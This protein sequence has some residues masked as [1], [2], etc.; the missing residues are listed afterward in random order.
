M[1]DRP[2]FPRYAWFLLICVFFIALRTFLDVLSFTK[3]VENVFDV[4]NVVFDIENDVFDFSNIVFDVENAVFD[5]ESIVFDYFW[6]VSA[7]KAQK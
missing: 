4:E 5:V 2:V 6:I 1:V 7:A 3:A